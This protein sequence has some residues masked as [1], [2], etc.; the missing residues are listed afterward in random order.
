MF[1]AARAFSSC[2]E[3]GGYSRAAALWL[4][5]TVASLVAWA[6]AVVAQGLRCPMACGIF[7]DQESN[8]CLLYWQ[9]DSLPL[10]H[11]RSPLIPSS[12]KPLFY[13]ISIQ[14]DPLITI[15]PTIFW[16]SVLLVKIGGETFFFL[17]H[18]W[19]YA[20]Y[21]LPNSKYKTVSKFWRSEP[22]MDQNGHSDVL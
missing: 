9:V 6:S 17:K 12:L 18:T 3:Y 16:F 22:V 1:I 21:L 5:I 10:G 15:I 8:L 14:N 7:P 4:L 19:Y 13:L 2:H 20:R 11:Q